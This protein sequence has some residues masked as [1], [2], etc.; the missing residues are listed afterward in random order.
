MVNGVLYLSTA[1]YQAAAIDARTGETLWIHDPRAYEAGTPPP[2][3]WRHR[4]VAYWEQ[5]GEARVVWGTGDGLLIAVD[6]Q[7][8]L[9]LSRFSWGDMC[10]SEN[11]GGGRYM[12]ISDRDS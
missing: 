7:T 3:P 5:D 1:L 4:G 2:L 9:P 11:R 8:G 12:Y 10:R 6:A